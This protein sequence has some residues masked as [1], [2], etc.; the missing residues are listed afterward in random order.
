[1]ARQRVVTLLTDFGRCDPYVAEMKG[2][3]LSICSDA[4]LVDIS[5]E[6]GAGDVVAG[7]FVLRQALPYFPPETVHCVVVDPGVGTERRI[8][9]ARY[10]DQTIVFPDNGVITLVERDQ[11][12]EAL[13]VVRDERYFLQPGFSGTFHGRDIMAPVAAHLANGLAV[14]RLGPRPERFQVLELPEPSQAE[15]GSVV[16]QVVYTDR[17]GNL[18]SNVSVDLIRDSL[19]GL[20]GLEVGC[21]GRPVGP[22]RTAYAEVE[23]HQPLALINSMSLLEVA[24]NGGRA[25]DDLGAGRDT[26]I[27]VARAAGRR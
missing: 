17:F 7:A 20:S 18:I 15:D 19:G 1:M 26:E 23:P 22:I 21:G 8:L 4:A 6:I 14:S 10:A 16:G 24:V 25:C 9:A 12:L 11:P 13:A 2:V 3:I 5:H 27:R